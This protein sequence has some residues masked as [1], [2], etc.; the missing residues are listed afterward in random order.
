MGL[1]YIK[2]DGVSIKHT[3]HWPCMVVRKVQCFSGAL[4]YHVDSVHVF[5]KS[6]K[7]HSKA[8]LLIEM[9]SQRACAWFQQHLQQGKDVH[10]AVLVC[11]KTSAT[12]KQKQKEDGFDR[13]TLKERH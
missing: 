2:E 10:V 8:L 1:S 9:I 3:H 11:I 5:P 6:E 7:V 12:V 13:A 4:E